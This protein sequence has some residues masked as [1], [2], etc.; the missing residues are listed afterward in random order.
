MAKEFSKHWRW[1]LAAYTAV[2]GVIL[3]AAFYFMSE[4]SSGEWKSLHGT[5]VRTGVRS[6]YDGNH[7]LLIVRL[8][9]GG[10][11][12]VLVSSSQQAQCSPGDTVALMQQGLAYR[13][14]LEGCAEQK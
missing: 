10:Q 6:D 12:Q 5:V 4:R 7:P 2:A 13:V 9:D 8:P 1:E 3:L 11:Q 14:A